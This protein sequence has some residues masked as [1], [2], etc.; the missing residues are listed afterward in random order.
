MAAKLAKIL[1]NPKYHSIDEYKQLNVLQQSAI[2]MVRVTGDVNLLRWFQNRYGGDVIFD[3]VTD[4]DIIN[5]FKE[6]FSLVMELDTWM[7]DSDLE[8][9]QSWGYCCD[10][11][12][13]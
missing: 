2:L 1:M 6:S 9:L 4:Q 8:Q 11:R 13:S 3:I 5:G 12:G 10:L 7:E